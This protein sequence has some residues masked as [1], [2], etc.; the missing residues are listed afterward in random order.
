MKLVTLSH[1][2]KSVVVNAEMI[3]YLLPYND[4]ETRIIFGFATG[5]D[6]ARH[7]VIVDGR[8]D[9]LTLKLATAS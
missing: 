9:E 2:G 5:K 8:I 6:P 4:S 7:S 1:R 3:A